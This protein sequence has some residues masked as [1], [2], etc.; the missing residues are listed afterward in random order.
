MSL[1]ALGARRG[2]AFDAL[3]KIVP[4]RPKKKRVNTHL[5]V[6]WNVSPCKCST[7]VGVAPWC[8]GLIKCLGSV[9]SCGSRRAFC[10]KRNIPSYPPLKIPTT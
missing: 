3:D 7:R 6:R 2:G 4:Q 10:H 1:Q 5:C 9:V 8:P